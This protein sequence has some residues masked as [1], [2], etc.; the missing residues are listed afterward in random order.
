MKGLR[1]EDKDIIK[2]N[3]PEQNN[4]KRSELKRISEVVI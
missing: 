1:S 2:A 4:G 3:N